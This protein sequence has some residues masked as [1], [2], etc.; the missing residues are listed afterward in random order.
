MPTTSTHNRTHTRQV[1]QVSL[2]A[3]SQDLVWR[4]QRLLEDALHTASLPAAET[5]QLL[6]IRHLNVGTIHSDQS[7]MRLSVNLEK[8]IQQLIAIATPGTHPTAVQA[9]V[10]S[11]PD[12]L[13]A[14]SHFAHCLCTGQSLTAWFWPR[15]LPTWNSALSKADTVHLLLSHLAT[16]PLAPFATATV[17]QHL[18]RQG[19]LSPLLA[20]FQPEDGPKLLAQNGWSVPI[21]ADSIPSVGLASAPFLAA[22]IHPWP[23]EDSRTLW[24]AAMGLVAEHPTLAQTNNLMAIAQRQISLH[25]APAPS[26]DPIADSSHPSATTTEPQNPLP[27][28]RHSEP[29]SKAADFPDD[30]R[31]SELTQPEALTL[32]S[33]NPLP[34]SGYSEPQS[35][36]ADF[37]DN[38]S[39]SEFTQ[40]ETPTEQS[41]PALVSPPSQLST[42]AAVP[43][44]SPLVQSTTLSGTYTDYAGLM[45]LLNLLQ[46]LQLPAYLP[47]YNDPDTFSQTLLGYVAHRLGVPNQDPILTSLIPF[48]FIPHSPLHPLWYSA[49][50][51]WSRRHT[52][53]TLK[54]LIQ[55]PGELALTPTHLDLTFDLNQVDIRIRKAGLDLN[56]GWLPW[57]GRVVAFHYEPFHE[58][59][60]G[61]TP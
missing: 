41:L 13:S 1:H 51:T 33:R 36:V 61:G 18:Y 55:R 56:P 34:G 21:F 27:S 58:R 26:S 4:G 53:L 17:L 42:S 38:S 3:P 15:L 9:P 16:H 35:K 48:A 23:I 30:F 29:Q 28:S 24:L 10:V 57:F 25:F 45:Y 50:K 7:A 52:G 39:T 46:Y 31:A 59:R 32:N 60:T 22:L 49:L 8:Q 14:Y 11:F 37:P 40:P 44:R 12:D 54:A 6:F 19:V 5:S 47:Q 43:Q 2:S 20:L